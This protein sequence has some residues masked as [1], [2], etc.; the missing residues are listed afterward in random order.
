MGNYVDPEATR[1]VELGPCRCPGSPHTVDT[2][3][4]VVRF[5]YGE[6]GRIRQVTR[7]SGVE[8]GYQVA[9]LLG[10]KRWNLV[11]PDG[12]ARDVDAEQIARLDET[13]VNRLLDDE[14]LGAAFEDEPLPKG[15][16]DPSPSGSPESDSPT[17]TTPA[18]TSSTST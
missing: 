4:I 18:P 9:I 15:P 16:G 1:P 6:R 2:A 8:A 3:D 13:T 17:P 11:L 7:V 10:V 12:S 5:G 14:L